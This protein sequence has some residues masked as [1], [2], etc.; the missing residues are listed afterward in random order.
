MRYLKLFENFD[1]VPVG[2][3]KNGF[4]KTGNDSWEYTKDSI[5]SSKKDS[6][7]L[8]KEREDKN[9]EFSGWWHG[10]AD[11][12]LSGK[13]GIHVGT[14]QAAKEA[15]EAAIGVPADG[16]DW[17]GTVEYGKRLLAG[18]KTLAKPEFK[19]KNTG[20]NC[21]GAFTSSAVPE[22]DY[23][24]VDRKYRATFS[25]RTE[26][27]FDVKP[28][29]LRVEIIGKMTNSPGNPLADSRANGLMMRG[30]RAGNAKSGFYYENVGED[31]GSI[32]AVV[33]DKSFL[34]II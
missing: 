14:H 11:A 6:D 13:R 2:T 12:T 30:I 1:D 31:E 29:M 34:K 18:R 23:Y 25:D 32:S 24:A 4:I 28:V 5:D 20:Y 8:K 33:P 7:N 10:T 26:V 19:Y 22:E 3:V 9:K 15:L 21:G 16:K 27:P 17:D